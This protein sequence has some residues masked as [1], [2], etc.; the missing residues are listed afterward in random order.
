MGPGMAI[1]VKVLFKGKPDA[2]ERVSFIPRGITLADGFDTNYERKTDE[3]G[4]AVWVRVGL[5]GVFEAR[6]PKAG[7]HEHAPETL[8]Q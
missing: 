4:V 3:Q 7:V 6:R 5:D 1:K 2:G 8:V